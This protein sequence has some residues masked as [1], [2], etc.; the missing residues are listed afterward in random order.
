M[1]LALIWLTVVML[2]GVA[3]YAQDMPAMCHKE[4]CE[5]ECQEKKCEM[6]CHGDI[7]FTPEQKAKIEEIKMNTRKTIVPVRAQIELKQIDME[8]EMKAEKPNKDKI[9]KIAQ[10][11]HELEW[12]IKKAHLEEKIAIASLLTPEQR[13]KMK[14]MSGK[15]M[16]KKLE[17][18]RELK[19]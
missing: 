15:K 18:R 5:M 8:K 14:M 2:A 19:D 16:I 12:Q 1:K 10:E 4:E 7:E 3:G 6:K 17:I 9:L 11:I 13:E